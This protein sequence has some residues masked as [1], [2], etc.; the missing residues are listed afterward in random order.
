MACGYN[1]LLNQ[2]IVAAVH[3][4]SVAAVMCDR[5]IQLSTPLQKITQ[6]SR[7]SKLCQALLEVGQLLRELHPE[8]LG[9]VS[10]RLRKLKQV[11]RVQDVAAME[12]EQIKEPASLAAPGASATPSAPRG[13]Q[14]ERDSKEPEHAITTTSLAERISQ[15]GADIADVR[16]VIRNQK[17]LNEEYVELVKE[18]IN[19]QA[20]SPHIGSN[21]P[22]A[23][24]TTM[25]EGTIGKSGGTLRTYK[26]K[27]NATPTTTGTDPDYLPIPTPPSSP[28]GSTFR[29]KRRNKQRRSGSTPAPKGETPKGKRKLFNSGSISRVGQSKGEKTHITSSS[30]PA[31]QYAEQ[32]NF[33]QIRHVDRSQW[34]KEIGKNIPRGMPLTFFPT[35]DMKIVGLDLCVA[36][37]IFNTKLD[38][39]ELLVR[40]PHC[41][42]TRGA[43]RTL[44]PRKPV[45]DDVSTSLSTAAPVLILLACMLAGNS[46]RIHWFLPTTFSQI[47]TGRGPVPYTTLKAIR[48]DFMGKANKV[49]KIYCPIWCDGHWFLL[50]IDVIRK[51]LV[52]LDSLPSED[53]R[54]KRLRQLKKVLSF[55]RSCWTVMIGMMNQQILGLCAVTT[56]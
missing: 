36:A 43:L 41:A 14:L 47:A 2:S 6:K 20:L 39:D 19:Q 5:H 35:K 54:P 7:F 10:V 55:W 15:I 56:R 28:E 25:T 49:C 24:K 29:L 26:R 9:T 8:G 52:Y 17:L 38:Q 44:E 34:G 13:S 37:Y 4:N 22:K 30:I 42:I 31:V 32:Q 11:L 21:S 12:K 18:M 51:Q 40:S 33:L 48:E 50:V 45:V 16:F 27:K 1:L 53:D 3:V 23:R 46:T